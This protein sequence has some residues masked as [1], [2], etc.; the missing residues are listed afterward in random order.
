[1]VGTTMVYK[2]YILDIFSSQTIQLLLILIFNSFSHMQ[3]YPPGAP[4]FTR[5][6]LVF[7]GVRVTRSLVFFVLKNIVCSF[8]FCTL[9]EGTGGSMNWVVGCLAI[10][11]AYHQYGVGLHPAL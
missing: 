3:H 9:Y 5:S 7:S 6:V 10:I 4:E 1:M 11:Q 8:F 2:K